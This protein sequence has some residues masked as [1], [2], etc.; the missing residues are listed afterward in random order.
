MEAGNV[1]V[2][3]RGGLQQQWQ[4]EGEAKK[5]TEGGRMGRSWREGRRLDRAESQP[6]KVSAP[7]E[8]E[9]QKRGPGRER[10]TG[11][12]QASHTVLT[13]VRDSPLDLQF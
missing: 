11:P 6:G 2:G 4:E 3:G 12:G 9:R 10:K 8:S 1:V 7:W 5:I 13:L